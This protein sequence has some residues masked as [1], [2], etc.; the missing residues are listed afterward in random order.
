[1]P[2]RRGV[3]VLQELEG[4]QVERGA[5]RGE[6]RD[7]D[8]QVAGG[9][10]VRA[11]E[12]ARVSVIQGEGELGEVIAEVLHE[13]LE[14]QHGQERQE[15]AGGQDA[16]DIAEVGGHGGLEVFGGVQ[17]GV[18]GCGDAAVQDV[19]V[20]AE[21]DRV[22]GLPGDPGGLGDGQADVGGAQRGCVVDAVAEVADDVAPGAQGPDDAGFV[23][24]ASLG[25]DGGVPGEGGE[26][27]EGAVAQAR[28]LGA[29]D[30][31]P[32]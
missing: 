24:R 12:L 6:A 23:Q 10:A 9:P 22:G 19:Q 3:E 14:R 17:G 30:R 8:G 25:E 4:D 27:G 16:Q 2:V 21:Q 13:Q 5:E 32:G 7:E 26:G 1:M 28:G 18:P 20:L 11:C 29:G 15:R 31:L